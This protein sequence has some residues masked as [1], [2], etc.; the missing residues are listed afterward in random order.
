[1][2]LISPPLMDNS[3]N[4]YKSV[5]THLHDRHIP[6]RVISAESGVP[7]STLAKIAQGRIKS[8]SIHHV[9]A[10]Y[11]FFN[12]DTKVTYPNDQFNVNQEG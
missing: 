8:P 2:G 10:L 3:L 7:F 11:D 9:Q 12:R 4:L 5:M 1:M 6:Q